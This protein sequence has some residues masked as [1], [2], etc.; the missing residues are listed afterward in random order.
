MPFF[1][2]LSSGTIAQL[3][4]IR[5]RRFRTLLNET[6]QYP[7][8]RSLDPAAQKTVWDLT[9]QGLTDLERKA[10]E[11]LASATSGMLRSFT[12]LD[13]YDNLLPMSE[14]Y[15]ASVWQKDAGLIITPGQADPYGTHRASLL[16][17]PTNVSRRLYQLLPIPCSFCFVSSVYLRTSVPAKT[18][19]RI[20]ALSEP[21]TQDFDTLT[22]W[23]RHDIH[24][25]PSASQELLFIGVELPA[26]TEIVIFGAQLEA[27]LIPTDYKV[28]SGRSGVHESCR[29]GSDRLQWTTF[30]I[31]N[32]SITLSVVTTH[33]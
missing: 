22:E 16:S 27:T 15:Q 10:V 2:Q 17:N 19:L 4:L 14:D 8:I 12:F 13:P 21:T 23:T 3:P 18:S 26:N 33:P 11:D 29:L 24:N 32:H 7:S 30:G 31:N 25:I 20:G 28:T 9:F 6:S 5:S 1:P